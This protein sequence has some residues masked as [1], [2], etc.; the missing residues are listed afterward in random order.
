MH[1]FGSREA[2]RPSKL[3]LLRGCLLCAAILSG[4]TSITTRSDSEREI[5]NQ[6]KPLALL[7]EDRYEL[8]RPVSGLFIGV[9]NYLPEAEEPATP[10]LTVGAALFSDVFY[11]GARPGSETNVPHVAG[12]SLQ[13]DTK[14]KE[15]MPVRPLVT[16]QTVVCG[17]SDFTLEADLRLKPSDTSID[18]AG[19]VDAIESTAL[20]EKWM[21]PD[22]DPAG[23]SIEGLDVGNRYAKEAL[24]T[25]YRLSSKAL[26]S[27]ETDKD[28]TLAFVGDGKPETRARILSSINAHV[29]RIRHKAHA[30]NMLVV[31]Y[32]A[33]H[34]F[35]DSDGES[36][37]LPA[38]ADIKQHRQLLSYRDILAPYYELAGELS[39]TDPQVSFLIVL[40]TCRSADQK[41]LL[42]APLPQPPASVDV[43]TSASPLQ[44]AVHW[45]NE[46]SA[47]VEIKNPHQSSVGIGPRPEPEKPGKHQITHTSM[48]S[49]LPVSATNVFNRIF[50]IQDAQQDFLDDRRLEFTL[51]GYL[52]AMNLELKRVSAATVLGPQ[53]EQDM[54]IHLNESAAMQPLFHGEIRD[55]QDLN[56]AIEHFTRAIDANPKDAVARLSRGNLYNTKGEFDKAI[57]DLSEAIR[58]DPNNANAYNNRA[59]AYNAKNDSAKAIADCSE[60]IRVDPKLETA[61]SNRGWLYETAGDQDKALADFEAAIRL[62]P[63]DPEAYCIRGHLYNKRGE[64]DKAI[65]DYSEAIRVNPYY[66][67]AYEDRGFAYEDKE[68]YD[69]AISDYSEA[70]QLNPGYAVAYNN[71]AAAHRAKHE[72]EDSIA[73]CNIAIRLSPNEEKAYKIRADAHKGRHDYDEAIADYNEAIRLKSDYAKAYNGLA[74][75]LAVCPDPKIRNGDEAVTNARRACDLSKWENAT[76]IETLAAANAEAG[77]F[78]EAVKWQTKCLEF[79]LPKEAEDIARQHLSL[80]EQKIPYHE[81]AAD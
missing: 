32:I 65:A 62:S 53:F 58:L 7:Y 1:S 23:R 13:P 27:L 29:E 10:A 41:T 16:E 46:S 44:F 39:E 25:E 35:I 4:C 50:E 75:L 40:D 17:E 15:Y 73:D 38:D 3:R 81:S 67:N 49:A 2:D 66:A 61:Y 36:Q 8:A 59:K 37:L 68:D 55:G 22:I 5:S 18:L 72:Y 43:V 54:E 76:F 74:W 52:E 19:V 80:F 57:E 64:H 71:R 21:N 28:G 24:K 33:A 6:S 14:W 45:E 26:A 48:V 69:K 63:K 47:N 9:G 77:N 34:G 31:F 79:K 11:R 60:A 78:E 56:A 51:G 20:G 12:I 70:I 30:P 42:P